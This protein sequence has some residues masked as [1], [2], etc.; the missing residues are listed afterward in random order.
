MSTL[1][2]TLRA[3][4]VG[5]VVA[6]FAGIALADYV[7]FGQG[8]GSKWDN[9]V[10]PNPAV[11]TWGF[12]PDG[13]AMHPSF[14]LAPEVVGVSNVGALRAS[15]DAEYGAGSFDAALARAFRTWHAVAGVTFVGPVTD[16][17]LAVGAPTATTPDIRI[18]AFAAAPGSGFEFVG[19]VGYGPPGD[20]LNFPDPVAGDV[21][22][23]LSSQFAIHPGAEGATFPT[24]PVYRND[25]EGLFLHE[26]GHA[27]MGL[28]HPA[29]AASEV[30]YVGAG[31]CVNINRVPSPDDATGARTVY[32][33]SSLTVC[34]N[35]IDDD[36]DGLVDLFDN[37][38]NPSQQLTENP[39]CVDGDDNDS[40]TFID[41]PFDPQ[42]VATWDNNEAPDPPPPPLCGLLGAEALLPLLAVAWRR[43]R[44]R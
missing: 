7:T 44:A 27:A 22:F 1:P 38:C 9:P 11:I 8:F 25:L 12:V 2:L 34:Q 3:V 16:P 18:G 23:N 20:D 36:E 41:F 13:T 21:I 40:D 26:L 31:C 15:V 32:G 10:H 19:A 28:G 17:G 43:R 42:C 24:F 37:G 6:G 5:I 4:L 39:Q 29:A 35:G 33:N 14:P 30:M